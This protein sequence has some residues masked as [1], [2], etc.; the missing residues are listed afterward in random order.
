MTSTSGRLHNEFVR[1][2]FLQTHRETDR[3]FTVSGVQLEESDRGQ[4]HCKGAVFSLQ[5][6][7]KVGSILVKASTLRIT[8]NIDGT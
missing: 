8:L 5:F 1:L 6:K 3:F 2:L 4:F 7:S